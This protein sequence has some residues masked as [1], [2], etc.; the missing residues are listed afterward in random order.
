VLN[1]LV[2]GDDRSDIFT[3]EIED[4][5]TVSILKNGIKDA[6]QYVSLKGLLLWKVHLPIDKNIKK[7][8]ENLGLVVDESLLPDEELSEVFSEPPAR[9]HLH[10]VVKAPPAGESRWLSV[11]HQQN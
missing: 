2:L 3:I 7:K 9:K 6:F 5:K 4:T 11:P 10:I 1:C 8:V